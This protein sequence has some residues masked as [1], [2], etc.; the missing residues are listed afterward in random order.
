MKHLNRTYRG[1]NTTT[2]V[3]SFPLDDA[4]AAGT[5]MDVLI[6]DIVIN[7]HLCQR[8]AE[9]EGRDIHDVAR[10]LLIHGLLHLAG[11]DHETGPVE[12]RRMKNRERTLANALSKVD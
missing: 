12:A 9:E 3:L 5:E 2:D 7:M 10:K 1:R 6:G 8:R 11:Y 4:S